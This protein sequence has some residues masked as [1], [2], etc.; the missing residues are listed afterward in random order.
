[1]PKSKPA[2]S[3]K[4]AKPSAP[5][6]YKRQHRLRNIV[7][8]LT[9]RRF[10]MPNIDKIVKALLHEM[11]ESREV[12]KSGIRNQELIIQQNQQI[13]DTLAKIHEAVKED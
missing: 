10:F 11:T 5:P 13:I 9:L 3:K 1:M 2:Q 8:T 7:D 4:S 12:M 6:K